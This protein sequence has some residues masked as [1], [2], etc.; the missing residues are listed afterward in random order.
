MA[1]NLPRTGRA[2]VVT[3]PNRK[4][5]VS[6]PIDCWISLG[7]N[8]AG[9]A[10]GTYQFAKIHA[11][12]VYIFQSTAPDIFLSGQ[13]TDVNGDT[14]PTPLTFIDSGVAT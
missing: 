3:T 12:G 5:A 1:L 6:S 9:D 7:S 2:V 14:V 13:T 10:A 4:W 11:G 8:P